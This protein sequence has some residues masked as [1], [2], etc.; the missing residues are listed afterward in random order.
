MRARFGC[1][2]WC[3]RLCLVLAVLAATPAGSSGLPSPDR[4]ADAIGRAQALADGTGGPMLHAF[5]DSRCAACVAL[6]R[7]LQPLIRAGRLRVRWIPVQLPGSD[8]PA[9]EPVRANTA[10]LT[11]LTG[12][13]RTPTLAYR[14]GDGGLRI[15]EGA[16]DDLLNLLREAR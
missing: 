8:A 5:V 15:R 13:V 6:K 4:L 7:R 14:A 11:L 9:P 16:P 1:P 2:R 10:L 12:T 3:R